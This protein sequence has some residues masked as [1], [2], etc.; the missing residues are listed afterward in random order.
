MPKCDMHSV[1]KVIS[2]LVDTGGV[3]DRQ[4]QDVQC[5]DIAEW[6]IEDDE[7]NLF[8]VCTDHI[9]YSMHEKHKEYKVSPIG[10]T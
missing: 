2:V 3:S 1:D 6:V 7:G 10:V 5:D 4:A 8:Y 9:G